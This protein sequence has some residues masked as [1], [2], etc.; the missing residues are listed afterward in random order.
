M[1]GPRLSI[2][3]AAAITDRR[4]KPRDL[5]VLALLGCHTDN[6]G[7]CRR[8]QVRMAGQ[9]GLG[10]TTVHDALAR[11]IKAGWVEVRMESRTDGGDAA[12]WYRVRLDISDES[13]EAAKASPLIR[14]ADEDE[15]PPDTPP[16]GSG[17]TPLTTLFN[18]LQIN[19]TP[20]P[21]KGEREA[22]AKSIEKANIGD[23][24]DEGFEQFFGEWV[25]ADAS[26]A[27]DRKGLAQ[28]AWRRL[29]PDERTAARQSEA[30]KAFVAA[31]RRAG[32]KHLQSARVYL[33][34]RA[35]E[36]LGPEAVQRIA[37]SR[38]FAAPFSR[39]W[40]WLWWQRARHG[41][42]VVQDGRKVTLQSSI[43][44]NRSAAEAQRGESAMVAPDL[45]DR[46]RAEAP[47]FQFVVIGSPEWD[48]WSA[49]FLAR[50]MTLP[51]PDKVDRVFLPWRLPPA[52]AA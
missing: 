17:P 37:S 10:R 14:T 4:L 11:L 6:S 5:Q 50:G 44:A 45:V 18:D 32:R 24:D 43:A 16:V 28:G 19:E 23:P 8:S 38:A 3:P 21:P 15:P 47:D 41:R 1:S 42:S 9:L 2:M 20:L 13:C 26:H 31:Q 39:D 25:R 40:W 33:S 51:R 22:R 36:R 29:S 49:W 46:M 48:A 34:E 52:E 27:A 12:H 30:I 35:W 7:W